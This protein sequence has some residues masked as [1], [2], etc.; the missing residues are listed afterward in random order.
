[1]IIS[2]ED[3]TTSEE[4]PGAEIVITDKDGN[5][6][7]KGTSDENGKVYFEVPAPGEY[8]FRET[9]APEGYELNETVFSFTVFEDGSILGDCTITDRKHYGRIMASYETERKGDG[10][11]TVGELLHAP[12]TGD[13]SGLAGLFAVWLASAAGLAGMVFW[14]RKR[15]K[16]DDGTPPGGGG[17]S[18]SLGRRWKE[19]G[20]KESGERI[21]GN[22]AIRPVREGIVGWVSLAGMLVKEAEVSCVRLAGVPGKE[23]EKSHVCLVSLLR[24]EW[25][26]WEGQGSL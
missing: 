13:T 23:A 17:A 11:V 3:V 25:E 1:M 14:R 19:K 22:M 10:D 5:E 15:K 20:R 26:M 16:G 4:L 6:V 7:F 8:H 18:G 21:A 24:K 9:V 2:K 12:K